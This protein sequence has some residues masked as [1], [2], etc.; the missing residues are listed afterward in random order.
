[1]GFFAPHSWWPIAMA[2][3]FTLTILGLAFGPFLVM[4]GFVALVVTASGF[5]FEYYVGI[6]RTQSHTLSTLDAMGE[7]P[8]GLSKFLGE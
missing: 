6:N 2:A 4:I 7:P 3:A 5:L 1:M 8:T